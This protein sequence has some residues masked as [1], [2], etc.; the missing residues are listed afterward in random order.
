MPAPPAPLIPRPRTNSFSQPDHEPVILEPPVTTNPLLA[1]PTLPQADITAIR[2]LSGRVNVLPVIARADIL[3]NDRLAAVKVAIRRDLADAGIGFGIF[4]VDPP[5]T[6]DDPTNRPESSNGYGHPNGVPSNTP[7]TSPTTPPLLR[8]PYALISP[9]MYSH[10]DGVSRRSL[11]RHELVQQY[12][13]ST[14]YT[15]PS[16]LPRGK[17]VRSYRWGILDVL[18]PSHSDFWALRNAI[19]HHMEVSPNYGP[20]LS[21][22]L[23]FF[24]RL[25]SVIPESI[26]FKSSALIITIISVLPH[27][28]L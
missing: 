7:P 4:D 18:D 11:A 22:I 23:I 20:N 9:D 1:R 16:Q 5:Y 17:F 24:D 13:P 25:C 3:S 6:Q 12:S 10:S 15:P 19:F 8:L 26:Y 21:H 2:R 14:H 28:I 27:A